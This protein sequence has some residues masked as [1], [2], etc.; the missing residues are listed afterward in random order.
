MEDGTSGLTQ[1]GAVEFFVPSDFTR[2]DPDLFK[3]NL[4]WIRAFPEV[5]GVIIPAH[6]AV[7]LL[8]GVAIN[9]VIARQAVTIRNEVVGSSNGGV[10]Q[11]FNTFKKPVLSG[12]ILEVLERQVT[13][14][15]QQ[16]KEVGTE[17]W[18]QW[19]EVPDFYAS[20]PLDR[21]YVVNREIGEI[22]FGDGRSGKIPPSG[23]RNIRMTMYQTG[24]GTAGNVAVGSLK[25]LLASNRRIDRAVNFVPATGGAEAEAHEALLD[26][27]PKAL[28]HR[29]RAVT[30]EDYEDLAKL[31]S[32]EVVRAKCVSLIDLTQ[33]PSK[34]ITTVEQETE[35]AGKVSIIIVP[36]NASPKPL[37]NQALMHKVAAYL[38]DHSDA[39]VALSVVGPLYLR[40]DITVQLKLETVQIESRVKLELQK[41]F[42]AFLHPLTGRSG[43]G[44]PF[45]RRPQ[46]SDIYRLIN[47]VAGINY[48]EALDI[49]LSADERPS[50]CNGE[51]VDCVART[52]RYLIYSGQ[53]T[54]NTTIK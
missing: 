24:G 45:G 35:G 52:G 33:E 43:Q 34:V 5:G 51:T 20:G 1:T 47:T 12:E 46:N 8:K 37:P 14:S 50:D 26:R 38:R 9:T 31:A 54:I 3:S 29:G 44:W 4:F 18:T 28:R 6:Q 48:V 41:K 27:A 36:R 11:I 32:T 10:G 17:E 2:M 39:S 13:V 19:Q 49:E 23:T 53:H 40:V 30:D 42:A 21:H 22:R 16:G 25:T 7:P 15:G